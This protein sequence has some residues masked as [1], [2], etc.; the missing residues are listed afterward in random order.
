[1]MVNHRKVAGKR[2][3]DLNYDQLKNTLTIEYAK[4]KFI[5]FYYILYYRIY[6]LTII[7]LYFIISNGWRDGTIKYFYSIYYSDF[8][9]IEYH[10]FSHAVN[11]HVRHVYYFRLVDICISK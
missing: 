10:I 5:S 3:P 9:K 1:M 6:L 8:E 2:R 7:K 11:L 4:L